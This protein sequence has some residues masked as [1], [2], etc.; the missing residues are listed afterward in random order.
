M[1]KNCFPL[2]GHQQ[3]CYHLD[4]KDSS[5][6][7]FSQPI[8]LVCVISKL[9]R[10]VIHS[11]FPFLDENGI[12]AHS[13]YDFRKHCSLIKNLLVLGKNTA[14]AF[15]LLQ[16]PYCYIFQ[17][18]KSLWLYTEVLRL[19]GKSKLYPNKMHMRYFINNL[20]NNRTIRVRIQNILSDQFPDREPLALTIFC[21][22]QNIPTKC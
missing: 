14:E 5:Q 11:L 2:V 13:Q 8:S 20:F 18:W 21:T 12:L 7:L 17:Y 22:K 4:I 10:I 3:H 1:P 9:L 15:K 16:L 19:Y 6:C